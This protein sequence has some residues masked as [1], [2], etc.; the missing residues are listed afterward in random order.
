M[1]GS[2]QHVLHLQLHH[3]GHGDQEYGQ[4]V[5]HDDEHFA[6]Y[7][8][9]LA[10]QRPLDDVDG[11]IA[12]SRP[13]RKESAERTQRQDSRH[14]GHDI[15]GRQQET[16]FHVHVEGHRVI[17]GRQQRVHHR[18]K[19]PGQHQR[20]SEADCREG[21]GFS[22]VLPQDVAAVGAQQTARR[23]LLGPFSAERETEVDVIE[24][25]R[26]QQ[27]QHDDGQQA[28]HL[29]VA[30]LEKAVR[31]GDRL[32]ENL[33]EPP[34]PPT[35]DLVAPD[36]QVILFD[37]AVQL[38]FEIGSVHLFPDAAQGHITA[39][40]VETLPHFGSRRGRD[41]GQDVHPGQHAV[42]KVLDDADYLI[43]LVADFHGFADQ[44]GDVDPGAAG[45]LP[46]HRLAEHDGILGLEHLR[47]P[48]PPLVI[49]KY[50]EELRIHF[51]AEGGFTRHLLPII[52][53][54]GSKDQAHPGYG[55]RL[56]DG[57]FNF[58]LVPIAQADDLVRTG[59]IDPLPIGILV[60]NLVLLHHVTADQ[61]HERQANRQAHRLDDGV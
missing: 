52:L 61:D 14:I 49:G 41:V 60:R 45:H 18:D 54:D 19:Q 46:G 39:D 51:H 17:P 4:G 8:P 20:H 26:Q 6:E 27:E 12:G 1:R 11:L 53:D 59:N 10:A 42:L 32:P 2:G 37:E 3:E 31:L 43:V 21:N 9:V 15:A 56:R 55:L 28:D 33:I 7:H 38:G 24:H 34:H 57:H 23:H 36:R 48:L 16:Q 25:R 58:L 50:V 30:G 35:F 44:A 5:L 29:L 22:D 40:A 47:Q 13:C